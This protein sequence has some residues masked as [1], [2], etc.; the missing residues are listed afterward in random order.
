MLQYLIK[1]DNY[2]LLL[3]NQLLDSGTSIGVNISESPAAASRADFRNKL[4][5]SLKEAYDAKF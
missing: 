2:L 4:K 3:Y 5:M 1:K